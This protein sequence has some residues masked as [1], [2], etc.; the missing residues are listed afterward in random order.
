MQ[1]C[2]LRHRCIIPRPSKKQVEQNIPYIVKCDLQAYCSYQHIVDK[3]KPILIVRRI[4]LVILRVVH[5]SVMLSAK[6]LGSGFGFAVTVLVYMLKGLKNNR[7]VT[8]TAETVCFTLERS[9]NLH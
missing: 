2:R 7:V 6:T 5:F 8:Y 1:S 4:H 9:C 3:K